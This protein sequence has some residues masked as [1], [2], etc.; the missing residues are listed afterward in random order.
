MDD[1]L[2]FSLNSDYI[3]LPQIQAQSLC[4]LTCST[5]SYHYAKVAPYPHHFILYTQ[6]HS[7]YVL[8]LVKYEC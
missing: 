2:T 3:G 8:R 7:L 5:V 4:H 6:G 1:E